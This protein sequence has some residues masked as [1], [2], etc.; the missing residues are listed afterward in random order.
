VTRVR[1]RTKNSLSR[2]STVQLASTPVT[3]MIPVSRTRATLQPSAAS[4]KEMPIEGTS[5]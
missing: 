1:R 4:E 3:M 5:T 2:R